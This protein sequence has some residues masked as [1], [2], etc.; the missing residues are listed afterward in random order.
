MEVQFR[1]LL[2]IIAN[3]QQEIIHPQV[4]SG[5]HRT[6]TDARELAQF[7]SEHLD[8]WIVPMHR[9]RKLDKRINI[10]SD[11]IFLSRHWIDEKIRFIA[12]R[13]ERDTMERIILVRASALIAF[14]V[15]HI[16]Y[17]TTGLV[18]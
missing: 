15:I 12:Y 1:V 17:P 16:I 3:T 14:V 9:Q 4:T 11:G 8:C 18:G 6:D 2:L 5:I 7:R 10:L 13:P